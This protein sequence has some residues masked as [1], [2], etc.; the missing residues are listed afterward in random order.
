MKKADLL[1]WGALAFV[2]ALAS[3]AQE[4]LTSAGRLPVASSPSKAEKP[5]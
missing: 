4:R 5:S 2:L 3:L 1:L